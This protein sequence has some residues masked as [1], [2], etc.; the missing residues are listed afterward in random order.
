MVNTTKEHRLLNEEVN[1]IW[2]GGIT[3]QEQW[4]PATVIRSVLK[5]DWMWGIHDLSCVYA[6]QR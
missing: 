5:Q 2:A 6:L 3:S 4:V 1:G